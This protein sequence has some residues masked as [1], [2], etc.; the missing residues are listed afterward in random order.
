MRCS[1]LGEIVELTLWWYSG[2]GATTFPALTEA[3]T[4]ENNATLVEYE[5]ERLQKLID[6]LAHDI[7][8]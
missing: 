5:A 7:K 1:C 8:I 4:I 6:K 2:Y 3:I